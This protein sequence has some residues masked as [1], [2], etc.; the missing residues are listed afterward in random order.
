MPV[1]CAIAHLTIRMHSRR[2]ALGSQGS[3]YVRVRTDRR[4]PLHHS[5]GL[6][7]RFIALQD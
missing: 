5:G 2:F 3:G 6:A 7:A 4:R 1:V